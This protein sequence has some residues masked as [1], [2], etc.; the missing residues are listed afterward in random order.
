MV[1]LLGG[2]SA[3]AV[4]ILDLVRVVLIFLFVN[5]L[6]GAHVHVHSIDT[7]DTVGP[8]QNR[9]LRISVDDLVL[10]AASVDL[11]LSLRLE[12]AVRSLL[13]GEDLVPLLFHWNVLLLLQDLAGVVVH[14]EL[15]QL[16]RHSLRAQFL[17]ELLL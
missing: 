5:G 12:T 1:D 8:N 9:A 16:F 6:V 4:F 11:F 13:L 10:E 15:R 7:D 3:D 2:T 17:S 14:L